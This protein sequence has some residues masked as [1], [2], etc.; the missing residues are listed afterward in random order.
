MTFADAADYERIGEDDRVSLVGLARMTPG[1]PVECRIRHADGTGETLWLNHTF[2]AQQ[3]EWFR[4]GSA[5]NV[6]QREAP[7]FL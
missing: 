4:A 2:S 6:T 3:I 7:A 1:K 5:L